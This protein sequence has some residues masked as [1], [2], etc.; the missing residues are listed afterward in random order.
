ITRL[1]GLKPN[2]EDRITLQSDGRTFDTTTITFKEFAAVYYIPVFLRALKSRE[3]PPAKVVDLRELQVL[4]AE[5]T[6]QPYR[7]AVRSREAGQSAD[8]VRELE[9]ALNIYPDYFRALNDLGVVY[10]KLDRVE[11][12]ARMFDRAIKIA[13]RVYYPRLNLAIINTRLGK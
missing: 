13:P 6:G 11:D 8:A 4:A 2:A 3:T 12:A 1:E 7:A 5:G 10:M 9:H